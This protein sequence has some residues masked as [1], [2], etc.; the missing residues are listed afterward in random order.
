M[1]KKNQVQKEKKKN[2]KT[3]RT[4]PLTGGHSDYSLVDN[5]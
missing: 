3:T 2:E 4:V 5:V 1:Q